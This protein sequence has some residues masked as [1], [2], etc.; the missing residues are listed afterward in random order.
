MAPHVSYTQAR[1]LCFELPV[2]L[3]DYSQQYRSSPDRDVRMA[4][5]IEAARLNVLHRSG[6]PFAAAVF[7]SADGALL[8]LGVNLVTN[9]GLSMLHAEMVALAL[10]QRK[11]GSY[12]LGS[13]GD[14]V[15][16][17]LSSTEPCAMCLGA[18]PW[19]GI[20][21]LVLAARDADARRIGFDEG[22]KPSDWQADLSRRGIEV[23]TEVQRRAAVS[24]LDF[25]VTSGGHL[26]NGRSRF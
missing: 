1:R 22:N 9:Q 12:D 2:W 26:Y 16:E 21:R 10:A 13:T 3:D 14:S 11:T 5:V 8:G 24:V 6:G 20:R 23:F 17:L 7:D 18:I 15:R 19:S 25:Y 4:F